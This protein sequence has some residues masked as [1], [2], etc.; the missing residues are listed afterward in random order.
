MT[1][2]KAKDRPQ[3]VANFMADRNL[4]NVALAKIG[5]VTERTVRNW[6]NGTQNVTQPMMLLIEAVNEKKL[7]LDWL[8]TKTGS[9][10][11]KAAKKVTTKKAG[12]KSTK[13][14]APKPKPRPKAKP[15][16]KK[17]KAVVQAPAEV[18]IPA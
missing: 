12:K 6:L 18:S 1:T 2:I 3:V 10:E 11:P 7:P 5:G 15:K 9:A 13:K 17:P 4:T 16:A 14:A 8:K